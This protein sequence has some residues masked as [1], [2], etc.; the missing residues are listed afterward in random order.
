[1]TF[2]LLTLIFEVDAR[3]PLNN[4]CL[5]LF[6]QPTVADAEERKWRENTRVYS[7]VEE[8]EERQNN[9]VHTKL[10]GDNSR[11]DLLFFFISNFSLDPYYRFERFIF[12]LSR[13]KLNK[14]IMTAYVT[15]KNLKIKSSCTFGEPWSYIILKKKIKKS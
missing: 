5:C 15:R 1:M 10:Q 13:K 12:F 3:A 2:L 4:I 14:K 7:D 6:L 11:S 8:D 9:D